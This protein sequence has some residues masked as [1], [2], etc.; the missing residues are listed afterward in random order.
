M[1]IGSQF[2]PEIL[3]SFERAVVH[4][5]N[6]VGLNADGTVTF[7]W[8]VP[9]GAFDHC[10]RWLRT[11]RTV[12]TKDIECEGNSFNAPLRS[13]HIVTE[14]LA[15]E[16]RNEVRILHTF[17]L[18]WITTLL[19]GS[20][21][22]WGDARLVRDTSTPE[23]STT[24]PDL[25]DHPEVNPSEYQ[26]VRWTGVNPKQV[27]AVVDELRSKTADEWSATING[28]VSGTGYYRLAV[29]G[30][31]AQEE[32]QTD[33]AGVVDLILAK[34]RF[35]LETWQRRSTSIDT[36]QFRLY[37]VPK[38]IA[39]SIVG[40][41]NQ[42]IQGSSCEAGKP[43][44]QGLVDLTVIE[45]PG[46]A[47]ELKLTESA[48]RFLTSTTYFY[49]QTAMPHVPS[50]TVGITFQSRFRINPATGRYDGFINERHRETQL[51][52]SYTIEDRHDRDGTERAWIGAYPTDASETA[53]QSGAL[54]AADG[55][56]STA[57]SAITIFS[58]TAAA[59]VTREEKRDVNDDGTYN[60]RAQ[61]FT[62]VAQSSTRRRTATLSTEQTNFGKQQ[63]SQVSAAAAQQGVIATAVNTIG[64]DGRYGTE[65]TTRTSVQQSTTAGVNAEGYTETTTITTNDRDAATTPSSS[66][67]VIGR[68]DS[69]FNEDGTYENR[70]TTR[71][72]IAMSSTHQVNAVG[73]DENVALTRNARNQASISTTD[74]DTVGTVRTVRNI[75][76]E[77]GSLD[78]EAATRTSQELS[79]TG[80]TDADGYIELVDVI[81]NSSSQISATANDVGI[82]ASVDN[83]RNDDGTYNIRD[84]S[85][86]SLP[87]AS[88]GTDAATG[89]GIAR[90]ATINARTEP[91]LAAA[92]D[93][94]VRIAMSRRNEDGS[95]NVNQSTRTSNPMTASGTR[96]AQSFAEARSVTHNS[97]SEGTVGAVSDGVM[98]ESVNRRNEDGSYEV[99]TNTRTSSPL[100]S[101]GT[102]AAQGYTVARS[103]TINARTEPTLAAAADGVVRV[104]MSRRNED[105]SYEVNQS[106]RTSSVL[107]S[108]GARLS[109]GREDTIST[110]RN[111]RTQGSVAGAAS[112]GIIQV[113]SNRRLDDGSYD[114]E[115]RSQTA[116]NITA[117]GSVEA[118][119]YDRSVTHTQNSQ[120]AQAALGVS[121]GVINTVD[122]RRN[123]D[124]TYDIDIDV[125][126]STPI[127]STGE[128]QAQGATEDYSTTHNA[129]TVAA[130]PA[131][132]VGLTYRRRSS[133]Q[134]DGTY[135]VE[136]TTRAT[137]PVIATGGGEN[138]SALIIERSATINAAAA[139][140][141]SAAATRVTHDVVNTPNEDG[142][143]NVRQTSQTSLELYTTIADGSE[144]H[145]YS[146]TNY[147]NRT[148]AI[149]PTAGGT[150]VINTANARDNN[151][152]THTGYNQTR[153]A[154]ATTSGTF[155]YN[156]INDVKTVTRLFEGSS[157]LPTHSA[158]YGGVIARYNEDGTFSGRLHTLDHTVRFFDDFGHKSWTGFIRIWKTDRRSGS[159]VRQPIIAVWK[160]LQTSNRNYAYDWMAWGTTVSTT[161]TRIADNYAE[162]IPG[163]NI[164]PNVAPMASGKYLA[165]WIKSQTWGDWVVNGSGP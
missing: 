95:Y 9:L 93:G 22:V 47:D 115:D 127:T 126:S 109:V 147:R 53:F 74:L 37:D 40:T 103:A 94:V 48:D 87:L 120:T 89:F 18:G 43:N 35:A 79:S 64:P 146:R 65:N 3:L 159:S 41:Y 55:V 118:T 139:A 102:D 134:D 30:S 119:G 7:R 143:V 75:K 69:R 98:V 23:G 128:F 57:F 73:Y 141:P 82:I 135:N 114:V 107:S 90:S 136:S 26:L 151:D 16:K 105:G 101:S 5:D 137:H 88:S 117:S 21:V 44:E 60:I 133:P 142:T 25:R 161:A 150:G 131:D 113:V 124:G 71:T 20:D 38:Y 46:A 1:A 34:P 58:G 122:N 162:R 19:D 78:V 42:S 104:A 100:A 17:K 163:C 68:A 70:E 62:S 85:R 80:K 108:S 50:D 156:S 12:I 36:K 28:E 13:Q 86:T 27:Q 4:E 15:G 11:N 54:S 132:A 106:T 158:T 130:M 110:T 51:V 32:G 63:A 77:D 33:K 153:T 157:T 112:T 92:S 52:A 49:S 6:R 165:T 66:I 29:L 154:V 8:Q 81:R 31:I 72:S 138:A 97:R 164:V 67:G 45:A 123:V 59:G 160:K 83:R 121:A 56:I 76:N 99:Q 149:S 129:A 96:A 39:Q 111:A 116:L 125:R 61:E 91:T 145:T 148:D 2:E 84:T 152:N 144:L 10:L 24:G 14:N 155:T 140:T